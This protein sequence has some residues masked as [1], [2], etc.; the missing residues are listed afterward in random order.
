MLHRLIHHLDTTSIAEIVVRL[1]G[2]E[3]QTGMYLAPAQVNCYLI[4]VTT[5]CELGVTL[6][7]GHKA[8]NMATSCS[9]VHRSRG[10]LRTQAQ[11][12]LAAA[13]SMINTVP[14]KL[15]SYCTQHS[16]AQAAVA[17][18]IM[19]VRTV[20]VM[21]DGDG[22]HG[23]A[24][25]TV[26]ARLPAGRPEARGRDPGAAS[27]R[28]HATGSGRDFLLLSGRDFA[29]GAARLDSP[30]TRFFLRTPDACVH[31][32]GASEAAC[33]GPDRRGASLVRWFV[34]L[35]YKSP[36]LHQALTE[37]ARGVQAAVAR[38]QL[39]PLVRVM[40]APDCLR[41]LFE[42]AFTSEGA[43]S[44]QVHSHTC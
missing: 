23:A 9:Y 30:P 20:G 25:G 33:K 39:S 11:L 8:G 7:G 5:Q 31:G 36:A 22:S 3:E 37:Q 13:V 28:P 40:S 38:S 12:C 6:T 19:S 29:V 2:A 17:W 15:P 4:V 21:V 24:A 41:V 42:R 1:V 43:S 34:C 32:L 18:L 14:L 35:K 44:V 16:V 10:H 26:G 27:I